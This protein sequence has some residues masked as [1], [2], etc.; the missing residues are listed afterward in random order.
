MKQ[1]AF[2][3][4]SV[5]DKLIREFIFWRKLLVK[6]VP[7]QGKCIHPELG[8]SFLVPLGVYID[9]FLSWNK[10]IEVISKTIS[11]G[12]GAVRKLKPHV[13]HNTLICAYNALPLKP[14]FVHLANFLKLFNLFTYFM[15]VLYFYLWV[16]PNIL[17][18]NVLSVYCN[19]LIF[20]V[21][22]CNVIFKLRPSWKSALAEG[23]SIVK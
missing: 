22:V 18:S 17:C 4:F 9:E 11:S 2:R 5:D 14:A 6:L 8:S 19:C 1:L 23:V 3:S 20:L 15:W 16:I 21:Y 12:I 7:Y 10:H 13:D